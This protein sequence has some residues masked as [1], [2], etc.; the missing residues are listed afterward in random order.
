MGR[1]RRAGR[2]RASGCGGER[3]VE[4]IQLGQTGWF[5]ILILVG[6]SQGYLLS[7]VFLLRSRGDVV[8]NRLLGATILFIT[9]HLSASGRI[10]S[11]CSATSGCT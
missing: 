3:F 6:A 4:S 11:V 8:A 5:G 9:L 10:Y 2:N 7:T 1:S